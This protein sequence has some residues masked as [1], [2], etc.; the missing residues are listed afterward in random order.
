M[1]RVS[2]HEH[3]GDGAEI[4][5]RRRDIAVQPTA[6]PRV[7][8]TARSHPGEY[9]RPSESHSSCWQSNRAQPDCKAER[10]PPPQQRR[11]GLSHPIF[12][13]LVHFVISRNRRHSSHMPA[14][15]GSVGRARSRRNRTRNS[16]PRS[17]EE[18]CGRHCIR[19]S[20]CRRLRALSPYAVHRTRDR[21]V[22]KPI[23]ERSLRSPPVS[24]RCRLS[25]ARRRT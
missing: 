24:C 9:G 1:K 13:R 15:T 25:N 20:R 12:H 4:E 16:H 5:H 19:R 23:P 7:Q 3:T 17:D 18:S 21:S 14:P 11:S 2:R 6:T 8:R 10:S 22:R